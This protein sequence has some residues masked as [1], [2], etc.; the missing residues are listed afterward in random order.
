M[1]ATREQ[2]E[3]PQLVELGSV[4]ELTLGTIGTGGDLNLL[5]T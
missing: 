3:D 2:Y 1:A 5:L 4:E